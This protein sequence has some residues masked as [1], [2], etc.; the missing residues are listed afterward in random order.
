VSTTRIVLCRHGETEASGRGRFCGALDGGL[1]PAG[2]NE[3][4]RL[5]AGVGAASAL[6]SSPARR[7]LETADPIGQ[8]LGL[9]LIVE[10]RIR[11]LDF[12][13]VDGL[14]YEQ[15]AALRP[16]LYDEWLWAPTRV[17][18]PGGEGYADLRSRAVETVSELV[19]KHEGE[20]VLIVTHAGV[21]R[22]LL[23]AWLLLPDE[24]VFRIDQRYG[25]VNVVDWL[26]GTPVVRLVNGQPGSTA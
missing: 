6:Y 17:R 16:E 5:A 19:S 24:A 1:S 2:R 11:E 26:N 12:G 20:T 10:P 18:F 15:V 3:A 23:A 13:E 22:A 8:R 14:S 9:A 4:A 7:A 25:S 21:T